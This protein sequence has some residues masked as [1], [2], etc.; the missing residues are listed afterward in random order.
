[1]PD[2]ASTKRLACRALGVLAMLAGLIF[3][4]IS[5]WLGWWTWVKLARWPRVDAT[6]V[7]K[8]ISDVGARLVFSYYA[9]GYRITGV[10]FVWGP[11][12][13]VRSALESWAPGTTQRISY[14]P[15]DPSEVEPIHGYIWG[16][17]GGSIAPA[18]F[19]ALFWV[20]GV[21]AYRGSYDNSGDSPN[22][23]QSVLSKN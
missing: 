21:F 2:P 5:G 18:M 11:S 6:L 9:G 17:W 3:L 12:A 22:V 16:T 14:D 19:S 4:C 23:E 15:A 7:S 1:M 20:G 13:S 10:G 8:N